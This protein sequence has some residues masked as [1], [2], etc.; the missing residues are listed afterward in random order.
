MIKNMFALIGAIT[1]VVMILG[2]TNKP[3]TSD[4]TASLKNKQSKQ[5]KITETK[6]PMTK[7]YANLIKNQKKSKPA[8]SDD[9][10]ET[11]ISMTKEY[12]QLITVE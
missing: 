6:I 2:L 4:S 11:K 3:K 12:K 10:T 5:M 7:E 1:C 8:N 9:I